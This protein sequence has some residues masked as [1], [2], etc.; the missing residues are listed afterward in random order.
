MR[1]E[2]VPAVDLSAHLEHVGGTPTGHSAPPGLVWVAVPDLPDAILTLADH[3]EIEFLDDND[4]M[5][6]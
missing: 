5:T 6:I 1:Y 4:W 3:F 2:L